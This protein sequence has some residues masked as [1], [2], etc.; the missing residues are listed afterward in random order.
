MCLVELWLIDGS[1]VEARI[2]RGYEI[3]VRKTKPETNN[4][5][6]YDSDSYSGSDVQSADE[7]EN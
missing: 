6:V 7:V 2:A 1:R 5:L 4:I 3:G